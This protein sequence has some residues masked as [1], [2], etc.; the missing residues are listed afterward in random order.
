MMSPEE[1][2]TL[3]CHSRTQYK[4][5]A[6]LWKWRHYDYSK[7]EELFTQWHFG[8]SHKTWIA[9]IAEVHNFVNSLSALH[10]FTTKPLNPFI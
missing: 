9:D 5:T 6:W 4:R 7:C 10:L 1:L 3:F 8:T 2:S